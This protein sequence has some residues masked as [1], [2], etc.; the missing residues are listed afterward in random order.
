MSK[1][2]HAKEGKLTLVTAPAGYG[3]TTAVLDMLDKCGLPYAWLSLDDRDNNPATFWRYVC[4]ALEDVADGIA[5]DAEYVFSSQ[6]LTQAEIH[7]NILI[8]RLSEVSSDFFLI[9]DDLH[10]INTTS[11]LTGLSHLIDHL[12]VKMHLIFISRT[13]PDP[14][15]SKHRIKWQAL[16]LGEKDLRFI[17]EEISQFY[18]ARGIT[19]QDNELEAVEKYTNGWVAALVAVTLSMEEGGGHDAIKALSRSSRDIGQYL[20]NEVIRSWRPEKLDFAMKSSILDTLWP[21]LCDAVTGDKSGARLLKEIADENGFLTAVDDQRQ[22]YRYHQ[23]F[24]SFL[25]ELLCETYPAEIP[26]LYLRAG[27]RLREQ[28]FIPEAVEHFLKREAL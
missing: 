17:Q 26:E 25:L 12:P 11:I 7:I 18:Q 28:G 8:D 20:R 22:A 10:L 27:L 21:E 16:R 24:K 9:L 13:L 3:K 14:D 4:A 15:W 23:L 5:T 2:Q 6:E 19:L 1:L